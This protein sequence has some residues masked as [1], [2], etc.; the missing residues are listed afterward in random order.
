MKTIIT[1]FLLFFAIGLS[2]QPSAIR[3]LA[4][5]APDGDESSEFTMS[6]SW[7][8]S[9]T[10]GEHED[11]SKKDGFLESLHFLNTP[12]VSGITPKTLSRQLEAEG[13]ELLT[14]FRSNG[15][16]GFILI[17]ENAR[18]ITDLVAVFQGEKEKIT[19]ITVG[20]EFQWEDLNDMDIDVDGWDRVKKE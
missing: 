6:G 15:D 8:R 13:Y 12:S 19:T 18:A 20:G 10:Q 9:L 2:A 16:E 7:L 1:S 17:K 11:G 3:A 4:A 5:Q 14:S